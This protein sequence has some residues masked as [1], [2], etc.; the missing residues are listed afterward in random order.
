MGKM[1]FEFKILNFLQRIRTPVGDAVMCFITKIG[2]AG[3]IWIVLAVI[4]LLI[5]KTRKTGI[6]IMVALCIDLVV[7]NGIL[8]NLFAQIRP[9]EVNTQIQLLI[10]RPNDFSFPSG[11]TASSFAAVAA[12]YF[13]GERKLWKPALVLACLIAFSRLYLYVHYPTDILGGILVGIAAGY[14]GYAMVWKLLKW[15]RTL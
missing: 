14:L 6:V 4:L 7:C 9:C 15:K 13:S 5:P 8:K 3:M 10:A 11:H 2:D 12:L 1:E